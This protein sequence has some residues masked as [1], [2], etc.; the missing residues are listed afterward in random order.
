MFIRSV[1]VYFWN[2]R[3]IFPFK[4]PYDYGLSSLHRNLQM[5]GFYQ[6]IWGKGPVMTSG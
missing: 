6:I 2:H 3:W 1:V 4:T 5:N